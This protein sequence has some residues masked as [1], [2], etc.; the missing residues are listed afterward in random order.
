MKKTIRL[1]ESDLRRIIE[2][3]LLDTARGRINEKKGKKLQN[4]FKSKED[5]TRYRD[6]YAPGDDETVIDTDNTVYDRNHAE[7]G[8]WGSGPFK[9][10]RHHTFADGYDYC[11]DDD[12]NEFASDY[13]RGMSHRLST[14][15][16][17]MSYDWETMHPDRSR[18]TQREIDALNRG[19]ERRQE[20]DDFRN[21]RFNQRSR[22]RWLRG[23]NDEDMRLSWE[24][25]ADAHGQ[26]HESII[27]KSSLRNIVRES[28]IKVVNE[29]RVDNPSNN[30]EA[31]EAEL[32]KGNFSISNGDF[33]AELAAFL[34]DNGLDTNVLL[35][36]P[37]IY[38]AV[39]KQILSN[40]INKYNKFLEQ[41][42]AD[43][44][45]REAQ[46]W[47]EDQMADMGFDEDSL[48]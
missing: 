23:D 16:G 25:W 44:K 2:N 14:K 41:D 33:E 43:D 36:Y 26:Q 8:S 13:N 18:Q 10:Y 27:R 7:K 47:A 32:S 42:R 29:A 5:M 37:H 15:G 1:T 39:D 38:Q 12:Y 9:D 28:L 40:E 46:A 19:L 3:A 17:Q 6:M 24:D 22:N 35:Q 31:V 45:R 4:S 30:L 11:G 21:G 34:C 20:I 48:A